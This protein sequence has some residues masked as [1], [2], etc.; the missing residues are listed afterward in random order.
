MRAPTSWRLTTHRGKR[1]ELTLRVEPADS[2][3]VANVRLASGE[4]SPM[5]GW[6][7]PGNG[8]ARPAPVIAL[9]LVG[10]AIVETRVD[11]YRKR[12]GRR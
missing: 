4:G 9:D 2:S 1:F 8:V 3:T 6:Y 7:S 11:A 12:A 5:M 10:E